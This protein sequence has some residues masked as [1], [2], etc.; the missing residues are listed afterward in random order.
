M[1]WLQLAAAL[2][3][4]AAAG[5]TGAAPA[6]EIVLLYQ[7]KDYEMAYLGK[8]EHCEAWRS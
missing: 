3:R 8:P 5:T 1:F 7:D 6:G 2:G 4:G